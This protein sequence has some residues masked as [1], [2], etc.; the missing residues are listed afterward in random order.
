MSPKYPRASCERVSERAWIDPGSIQ[1]I[2]RNRDDADLVVI[3]VYTNQRLVFFG[4]STL[5][6]QL[7]LMTV[8]GCRELAIAADVVANVKQLTDFD[9]GPGWRRDRAWRSEAGVDRE[10]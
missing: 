3:R 6:H 10:R 2:H 5:E 7:D 1:L 8:V 4:D 9:I